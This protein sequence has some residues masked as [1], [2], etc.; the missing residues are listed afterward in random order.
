MFDCIVSLITPPM[1]G[2]VA[3]IRMSG[4]ESLSITNRIFSRVITESHKVYY[5]FIINKETG[6]KIDEVMVSYFKGPR[7]FTGEDVVEISCHG[8]LII[9]NQII[10]LCIK[11]GAR[12]SERG[13]FSSRAFYNGRI[14]LVQA[15]AINS[16]INAET[17][18]AKRLQLFSLSGQTSSLIYPIKEKLA[19]ILSLIE[20]NI[21]YPEYQDIEEMTTNKII[22]E[23]DPLIEEINSLIKSG[24]RSKLIS[25]GINVAIIGRP[26]VGKSSLLN[27]LLKQDKAIVTNIPGTTRD[28]VEG[29]INLN[30]LVLNLLDTA[31]IRN[32]E[33]EVEKIG[34]EKSKQIAEQADLVLLVLEADKTLKEDEELL[35]MVKGY[36]HL[37]VYNKKE[38]MNQNSIDSDKI[39]ISALNKDIDSLEEAIHKL[40][41]L[42][43]MNNLEP[44]LCSSR[45]IGLLNKVKENLL[46]AKQEAYMC[47]SLDLVAISLKEA[48]DSVKNI[49]GEETSVDLEKEIFSRFCLGK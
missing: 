7:S 37:V 8:S 18:Q 26:N 6:E 16:L 24:E 20:V 34:I 21:D 42:E 31:G 28:V 30:G 12:I 10:E 23:V 9:V 14:D 29:K 46:Q 35:E 27:A 32:S 5:G 38:L 13:E 44:S 36:K 41:N 33:D 47:L 1:K 15:E 3:V 45:E 2:A 11:Y 17:L 39:Y 49:L 43:E 40:F 22:E 4:E 19:D 25:S 48:Y